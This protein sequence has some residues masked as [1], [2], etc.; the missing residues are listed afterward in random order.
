MKTSFASRP[1]LV[2]WLGHERHT[3]P[4][5]SRIALEWMVVFAAAA[6]I[7]L[8]LQVTTAQVFE[9]PSG[10][11]TPA[12][13]VG[14]RVLVNKWSYRFGSPHRGDL[15]VFSRPEHFD[16]VEDDLIKRVIAVGG[17]TVTITDN[18]VLVDG[19]P[20]D[21]PYLAPGTVTQ[22]IGEEGCT[23]EAPCVIPHGQVWVMGDN[24]TNSTD[25]RYFGPIPVSSI[26]GQAVFR[27]WPPGRVGGI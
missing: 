21:E 25:S 27:V 4:S 8:T 19:Q 20:I 5:R 26:V 16:S 12:L 1:D 15:V 10:S 17:E 2:G 23:P 7:A 22:P 13:Q 11:M 14:D 24:R 6:F 18:R 9:I 3:P